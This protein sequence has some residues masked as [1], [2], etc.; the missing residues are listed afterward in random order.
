MRTLITLY[1]NEKVDNTNSI[2]ITHSK[3]NEN[4]N[5]LMLIKLKA[6]ALSRLDIFKTTEL[7]YNLLTIDYT[8][9]H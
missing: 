8:I 7:F 5:F 1:K 6:H 3:Q 2:D 9:I 4:H